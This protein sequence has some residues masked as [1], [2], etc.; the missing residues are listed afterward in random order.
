MDKRKVQV[1]IFH[2]GASKQKE[3]LLLKTN[4]KRGLFWQSVTGGV[5]K[6]EA[7]QEA[8]L[9][10]V[11]EETSLSE[12]LIFSLT[13]IDQDFEFHDR[14]GND[15]IEKVFALKLKKKFEVIIDPSEHCDFKWV[16]ST[17]INEKSVKYITNYKA[18]KTCI[19][20]Y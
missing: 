12:E 4:E 18:I 16:N 10:E 6:N 14:W 5:E 1:V 20:S 11:I 3:F 19:D 9:R 2:I 7:Y 17:D 13:D 8:A 15:V